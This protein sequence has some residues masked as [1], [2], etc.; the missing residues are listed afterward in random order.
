MK[1]VPFENLIALFRKHYP[2]IIKEGPTE[3]SG[4]CDRKVGQFEKHKNSIGFLAGYSCTG[5]TDM[6][7]DACYTQRGASA[8]PNTEKVKARNTWVLMQHILDGDY[9]GLVA[10]MQA[11]VSYSVDQHTKKVKNL[12]KRMDRTEEESKLLRSL[13]KRG[14]IFRWQWSGDLLHS[15]QA[16][17]VAAI[18]NNMPEVSFWIYTRSFHLLEDLESKGE[19]LTVWLSADEEN[20]ASAARYSLIFPWTKIA[21]MDERGE[22]AKEDKGPGDQSLICPELREVNPIPLNQACASCGIC[23][24]AKSQVLT[25]PLSTSSAFKKPLKPELMEVFT[26]TRETHELTP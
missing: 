4:S 7:L 16:Q 18:S 8:W 19:N 17:A 25:F 13:I 12:T 14:P 11:V 21:D 24:A 5:A 10:K 3:F 1:A 6:C 15:L 22:I 9:H 20:M 2:D 26:Q 23:F